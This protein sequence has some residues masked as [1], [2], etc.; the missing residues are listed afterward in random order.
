LQTFLH[1]KA[2]VADMWLVLFF[3][4]AHW[5]AWEL[6]NANSYRPKWWWI[7][8]LSLALGF[9]A[10]GPVGWIP[11]LSVVLAKW[12]YKETDFNALFR[13]F[14]GIPLTL[15]I[16]GAWGV[17]AL[18]RTNGEFFRVGIVHHVIGRSL[19]PM[20]GHGASSL[21]MYFALLPFYFLTFLVSFFP[22]S[23]RLLALWNDLRTNR[24]ATDKFLLSGTLLIFAIFTLVK[25]KLPHY[26]LPAF[27]LIALLLARRFE[28]VRLS[29][30]AVVWS[31]G[32]Y[33]VIAL[34]AT[35]L[36][37][38]FFPSRRLVRESRL[39]LKPE[40]EFGAI[41]YTEPSLVWYFRDQ[42]RGFMTTLKRKD[43]VRYMTE[44]GPRFTVLPTKLVSEIFPNP[45]PNWRIYRARG[46]NIPK[47][48]RVD[49]TMLLKP[50]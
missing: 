49:L 26:T 16:V 27:P 36:L 9:L 22:W 45:D 1:G 38:Q 7:F 18:M 23:T 21:A 46:F 40:M 24:D 8:Y 25:T 4:L 33:L 31:A 14:V 5:S 35:P 32:I 17:P 10:K 47:G 48:Q 34:F 20:E 2:A 15:A 42:V 41:D 13:F 44:P 30:S 43:A 50:E 11:L 28:A 3:T 39:D 6:L 12:F 29:R 37:A 19:A